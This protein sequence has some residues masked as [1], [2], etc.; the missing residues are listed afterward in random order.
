MQG[1][2]RIL[3]VED[4]PAWLDEFSEILSDYELVKVNTV[5]EANR[6]IAEQP[7]D[8]VV[9]DL[10]LSETS[11]F[12]G[13]LAVLDNIKSKMLD[14]P[15]VVVTGRDFSISVANDLFNKY[16]ISAGLKKPDEISRL[17]SVVRTALQKNRPAPS[18]IIKV[19]FLSATP[20]DM[21]ILQV[22]KEYKTVDEAV[23]KSEVRDRYE[24][25]YNPATKVS[26][27]Q[28]VLLR[29]SP[30]I[31]HFSGHGSQQNEIVLLNEDGM[32]HPVSNSAL[33]NLFK[34]VSRDN[35]KCVVLNACYSSI[36]AK[37]IV[38]NVKCVIGMSNEFTDQAAIRFSTAFY[39]GLG[40]GNSIKTAFDLGCNQLEL[41]SLG[42][43]HI[44]KLLVQKDQNP[45]DIFLT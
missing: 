32:G 27:V 21:A 20:E 7:F 30:N 17:S 39:Q 3:I 5:R 4:D 9:L 31:V 36:Q 41:L 1:M 15:C 29:F 40:Y 11:G 28:E 6:V 16:Q 45:E 37:A 25:R 13:G 42:E 22:D 34:L 23:R 43:Q 35:I 24:I 2:S 26:E 19:L 18:P 38:K 44:P 8:L 33:E 10:G 14:L 12:I